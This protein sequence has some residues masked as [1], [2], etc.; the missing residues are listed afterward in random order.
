MGMA[1]PEQDHDDAQARGVGGLRTAGDEPASPDDVVFAMTEAAVAE[2]AELDARAPQGQHKARRW[3][4]GHAPAE[5]EAPTEE[6]SADD[7]VDDQ[8]GD[9]EQGDTRRRGED[10]GYDAGRRCLAADHTRRSRTEQPR[11]RAR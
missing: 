4:R 7:Q 9:E 11:R 8:V 6:S 10:Q 5:P 2:Q 3:R 1:K